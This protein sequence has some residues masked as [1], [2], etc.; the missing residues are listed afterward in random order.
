MVCHPGLSGIIL[1]PAA[2]AEK[3]KKDSRRACLPD[4]QA[5]MTGYC[6]LHEGIG[7][8]RSRALLCQLLVYLH[9]VFRELVEVE[10]LPAHL[11]EFHHL[12]IQLPDLPQPLCIVVDSADEVPKAEDLLSQFEFRGYTTRVLQYPVSRSEVFRDPGLVL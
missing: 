2:F 9:F 3:H 5:G 6:I 4:R 11:S 7:Q 10:G 1:Q 8:F 12:E